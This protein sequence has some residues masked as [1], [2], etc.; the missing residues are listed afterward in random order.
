MAGDT[1]YDV[2]GVPHDVD[3][4]TLR[5]AYLQLARRHHPDF[6]IGE[7]EA[8]V[9][10]SAARMRSIN[11][12]WEVLG[13]SH[14]RERYNRELR[15]AGLVDDT[16]APTDAWRG[17]QDGGTVPEYASG[18]APPRWLTMAPPACLALAFS[19]FILGFVTN[20]VGLLAIA[21]VLSVA[22]GALFLIV[23]LVALTR[24]KSE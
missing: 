9:S 1:Y 21:L 3:A 11:T 23:P 15:R 4:T 7:D 20:L 17:P 13:D 6:H 18:T 22:A 8:V 2:L 5:S 16:V 14:A 24:S 10:D 12:A 19:F